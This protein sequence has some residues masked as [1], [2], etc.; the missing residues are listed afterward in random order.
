LFP[1]DAVCFIVVR[2]GRT[3]RFQSLNVFLSSGQQ[4]LRARLFSAEAAFSG[5]R[6]ICSLTVQW[7]TI[8]LV[9]NFCS[10]TCRCLVIQNFFSTLY[11]SQGTEFFLWALLTSRVYLSVCLAVRT[12][13]RR[14]IPIITPFGL[15]WLRITSEVVE[16]LSKW[17]HWK[18]FVELDMNSLPQNVGTYIRTINSIITKFYPETR[19]ETTWHT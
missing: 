17:I 2:S 16:I 13:I 4:G 6:A 7:R 12:I 14:W 8:Q 9:L 18:N 15:F 5:V 11:G 1:A 3:R 19:E 10:L